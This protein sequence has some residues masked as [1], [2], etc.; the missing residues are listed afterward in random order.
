MT[1]QEIALLCD[2]LGAKVVSDAAYA[3]MAGN[4]GP[5][6][7]LG[8]EAHGL[9]TLNRIAEIAYKLMDAVEQADDLTRATIDAAKLP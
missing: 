9:A 2:R 5:L 8:I 6:E 7:T 1:D 4:R 3:A